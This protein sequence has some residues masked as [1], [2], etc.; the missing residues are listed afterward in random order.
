MER[1]HILV[2]GAPLCRFSAATPQAWPPGHKWVGI[3]QRE[4]ATCH[5]CLAALDTADERPDDTCHCGLERSRHASETHP[6]TKQE[7]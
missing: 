4:K 1:V 3:D 6:F 5:D 2:A 7:R